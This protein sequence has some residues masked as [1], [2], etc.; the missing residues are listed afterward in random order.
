MRVHRI[1]MEEDAGKLLHEGHAWSAEKSGVD[2][3]RSG[4]P[5]IEIVSAPD[6]HSAQ[7]AH[8]YLTALKAVL[9]YAGVSD[10]NME[11]GLAPLR[12]QRLRAP[13][14][15]RRRWARAPRSRT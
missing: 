7:E 1:H 3:N 14:R 6:L 5:L 9:L 2:F 12:R 15:E 10:C 4:V 8:D 13:A 11:E